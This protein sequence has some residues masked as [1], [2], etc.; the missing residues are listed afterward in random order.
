MPALEGQI[1]GIIFQMRPL[2]SSNPI[3]LRF[4]HKSPG[5]SQFEPGTLVRPGPNMSSPKGY[6]K[7]GK[8]PPPSPP[9]PFTDRTKPG[10][11]GCLAMATERICYLKLYAL[12]LSFWDFKNL[13]KCVCVC[14]QHR[15]CSH[16]QLFLVYLFRLGC[17]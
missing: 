3:L 10:I 9:L 15:S 6:N 5:V 13:P 8:D 1:Y 12:H 14:T 17:E 11:S 7:S 4:H 2:L 16:M